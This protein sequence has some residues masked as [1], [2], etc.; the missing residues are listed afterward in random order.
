MERDEE[1]GSSLK[2]LAK[3]VKAYYLPMDQLLEEDKKELG[4]DSFSDEN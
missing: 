4:I 2:K 1:K 3:L